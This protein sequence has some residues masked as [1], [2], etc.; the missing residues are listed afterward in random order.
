MGERGDEWREREREIRERGIV[1]KKRTK[2]DLTAVCMRV[3]KYRY[4]PRATSAPKALLPLK[5]RQEL[6]WF[7]SP[8]APSAMACSLFSQDDSSS[9][10]WKSLPSFSFLFFLK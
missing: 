6:V 10:S 5:N 7:P 3:W 8:Y 2:V 9:K 4:P 1:R